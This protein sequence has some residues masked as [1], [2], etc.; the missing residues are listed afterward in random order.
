MEHWSYWVLALGMWWGKIHN[1]F[2][3]KIKLQKSENGRKSPRNMQSNREKYNQGS[4]RQNSH[5]CSIGSV[6][7]GLAVTATRDGSEQADNHLS[8]GAARWKVMMIISPLMHQNAPWPVH[9]KG[10]LSNYVSGLRTGIGVGDHTF[11]VWHSGYQRHNH[12]HFYGYHLQRKHL[13]TC[14]PRPHRNSPEKMRTW[15]KN[16]Q[17]EDCLPGDKLGL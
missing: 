2:G 4:R 1:P 15:R 17:K 14:P 16:L 6:H 7:D 3:R 9:Q 8:Q 11:S 5:P 12:T 13:N 10:R